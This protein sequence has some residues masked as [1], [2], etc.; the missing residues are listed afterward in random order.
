MKILFLDLVCEWSKRSRH[1]SLL[2][3]KENDERMKKGVYVCECMGASVVI[4]SFDW[5][6]YGCKRSMNKRQNRRTVKA[7]LHMLDL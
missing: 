4:M 2:V 1:G 5:G 7:Q 6:S 3:E